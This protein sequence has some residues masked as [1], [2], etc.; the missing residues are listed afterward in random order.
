M[1]IRRPHCR[2]VIFA[3]TLGLA[4]AGTVTEAQ[5]QPQ[6]M[7]TDSEWSPAAPL[8]DGAM[9][10]STPWMAIAPRHQSVGVEGSA[11]TLRVATGAVVGVAAGVAV[12]NLLDPAPGP[13][14][15]FPASGI[16]TATTLTGLAVG[17]GVGAHLANRREESAIR[18]IA[19][20]TLA[21]AVMAGVVIVSGEGWLMFALPAAQ[22]VAAT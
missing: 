12:G 22:V 9:A 11:S 2:R 8:S 10:G 21:G 15:Y 13:G 1:K 6:R 17:P 14:I 7:L 19:E 5:H 4:S 18:T 20:S 3:L 16:A